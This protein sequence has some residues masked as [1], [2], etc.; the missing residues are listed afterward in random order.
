M[1]ENHLFTQYKLLFLENNIFYMDTH[2]VFGKSHFAKENTCFL[3]DIFHAETV[4]FVVEPNFYKENDAFWK[5]TL[6]T[7]KLLSFGKSCFNKEASVS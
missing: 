1:S 3:E 4:G 5:N 6:V 2:C 7:G